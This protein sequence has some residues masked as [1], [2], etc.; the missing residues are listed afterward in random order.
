MVYIMF[1]SQSITNSITLIDAVQGSYIHKLIY[2][3]K[4]CFKYPPVS[5]HVAQYTFYYTVHESHICISMVR[6]L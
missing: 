5:K 3:C 1:Q 6:Y 4:Q 2:S